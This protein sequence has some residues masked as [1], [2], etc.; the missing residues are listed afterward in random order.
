[1]E[2][3]KNIFEWYFSLFQDPDNKVRIAAWAATITTLTFLIT[4]IFRPSRNYIINKFSNKKSPLRSFQE[5]QIKFSFEELKKKIKFVVIDDDDIFPVNGFIEF[6]Y[7]FQK[8]DKLDE[9]KL[10][11]L[12]DGEF[13]VIILDIWGVAKEI[14]ENDGLDVLQDL[15]SHNP[16][17]IVVAY[18]GHSFDL[19]KNKFWELADEKLSKPTPFIGTQKTID[20]L[21]EKT[22]TINYH[23]EKV[24]SVLASNNLITDLNKLE[25]LF[26]RHKGLNSEP[27]WKSE[28][29]SFNLMNGEKQKIASIFKKLFS[30]TTLKAL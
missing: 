28:L 5:L 14:A 16:S 2:E 29:N 1:M 12:H 21:I 26:V 8:W 13:D 30:Y 23:L 11:R 4:F 6:G 17:Q 20:N 27:D 24:K 7:N 15:K 10:K 19:S 25:D 18:S 9:A 22:F 3:Q